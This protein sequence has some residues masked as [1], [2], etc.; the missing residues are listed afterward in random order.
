M[1]KKVLFISHSPYWGGAEKCLYLLLKGLP[2]DQFEPLV[3][4]PDEH[5]LKKK[6]E[7]LGIE[8]RQLRLLPWVRPWTD[9]TWRL[10]VE[11]G[12]SQVDQV[13]QL[14][15]L[16]QQEEIDLVFTNTS[17]IVG[18]ALAALKCGVPHVWHQLEMISQDP[19]LNPEIDLR[20]FY[21]LM[22]LLS[23]RIIAASASVKA[24]IETF[25]PS[26]KTEVV[27]TGIEPPDDQTVERSKQAVFG[28][29]EDTFV[30]AFVGDL[31]ER[32]GV[33][34]LISSAPAVLARHPNV[35]FMIV[36]GDVAGGSETANVFRRQ[37]SELKL[38]DAVQMLGFRY[39]AQNIMAACDVFVLPALADP[40]PLV[41]QEAMSVGTPVIATRSGGCSDMVVDGETGLLIPPADPEA[42][43]RAINTM[44]DTPLEER[45]RMGKRGQQRLADHFTHQ[46]YVQGMSKVFA[47]VTDQPASATVSL[48]ASDFVD[49]LLPCLEGL[50]AKRSM[51]RRNE[52]LTEFHHAIENSVSTRLGRALTS[53]LRGVRS[54]LGR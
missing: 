46:D 10:D 47:E 31:G 39:D 1:P 12:V 11:E 43:S 8:T 16:I 25:D 2:R 6:I 19:L 13:N 50:S 5:D 40:L 22:N 33:Q 17:V 27:H 29:S 3:V 32:K 54:L 34:H 48:N 53:P 9:H 24:D 38:S 51:E 18:G 37:L 49:V 44:I 36:G 21:R 45:A 30:V 4:L 52:E 14:A 15:E 26:P 35:R 42:L 7:A 20:Q 23:S 41:V 28:V